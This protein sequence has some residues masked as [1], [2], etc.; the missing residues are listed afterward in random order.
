MFWNMVSN[1]MY[2]WEPQGSFKYF[3]E[4]SIIKF[5]NR[6]KNDEI[7]FYNK[8]KKLLE[9]PWIDAASE[10]LPICTVKFPFMFQ[11]FQV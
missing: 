6:C 4:G 2:I 7:V 11:H 8:L 5:Y 3:I 1:F 9:S 10:L